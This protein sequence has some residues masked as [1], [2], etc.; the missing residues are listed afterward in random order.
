MEGANY[1]LET[2]EWYLV[3]ANLKGLALLVD[4]QEMRQ[5]LRDSRIRNDIRIHVL[6]GISQVSNCLDL[7]LSQLSNRPINGW[8]VLLGSKSS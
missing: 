2:G 3:I 4:G 5:A 1:G 8:S 6:D 7:R